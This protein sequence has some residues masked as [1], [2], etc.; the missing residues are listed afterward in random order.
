MLFCALMVFP[1]FI[2]I[3]GKA[4][5]GQPLPAVILL[6]YVL[7]GALIYLGYGLRKSRLA[8]E[9]LDNPLNEGSP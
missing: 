2:D 3:V 9:L 5:H 7:V 1:V 6:C 4:R 8:P